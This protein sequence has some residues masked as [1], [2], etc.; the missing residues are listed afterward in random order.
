MHTYAVKVSSTAIHN[1]DKI[2]DQDVTMMNVSERLF[3]LI[4]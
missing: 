1:F 4:N 3:S 2:C